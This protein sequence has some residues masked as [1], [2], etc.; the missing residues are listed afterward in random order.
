METFDS[1]L[2][3][4]SIRRFTDQAIPQADLELIL[5]AGFNAPSAHRLHPLDYIIISE[6]ERLNGMADLLSYGRPLREAYCAICVVGDHDKQELFDFLSQDA[7]AS[8]QNMALM[9]T[10]LGCASVWIGVSQSYPNI[11]DIETYLGLPKQIKCLSVL[12]LGYPAVNKEANDRYDIHKI[13]YERWS[14]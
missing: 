10:D 11:E 12:A 7:A 13:H 4:R 8:M 3:R 1:I 5:K 6:K 14:K 2:K 9:A